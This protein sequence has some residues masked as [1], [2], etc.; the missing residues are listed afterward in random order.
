MTDIAGKQ[1]NVVP[2]ECDIV[3]DIRYEHVTPSRNFG[4]RKRAYA[5]ATAVWVVSTQYS[6]VQ[7]EYFDPQLL[8]INRF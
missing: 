2:S 4:H 6:L 1:H 5:E 3:V 8:R 7:I